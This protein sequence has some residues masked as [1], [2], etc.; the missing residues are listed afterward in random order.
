MA[1]DGTL[2]GYQQHTL[3]GGTAWHPSGASTPL[4][5]PG[6][7]DDPETGLHYN[8]QRYYD[9]VTGAYLSPDPLGLAPSPNPHAYVPNPHVLTDPL[10]L[11]PGGMQ[12]Y[13]GTSLVSEQMIHAETGQLMSDAARTAYME[14]GGSVDAAWTAS[15]AAHAAGI[16]AWGSE[17]DYAMAHGAFGQEISEIGPRSMISVTTDPAIAKLFAGPAGRVFSAVVDPSM[18][19]PQTLEGAGESE[20]LIR[21]MFGAK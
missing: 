3:W 13:R 6:Q 17:T 8:N 15:E 20:F 9:P 19:I 16:E 11:E 4:R 14:S 1:P 10:G 12:V 21:H 5:F 2:A 18:L 7:Y